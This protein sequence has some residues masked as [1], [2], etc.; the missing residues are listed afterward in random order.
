[1]AVSPAGVPFESLDGEAAHVFVLLISPQ[2]RPGD[3]LRALRACQA[4][5]V[6]LALQ[7]CFNAFVGCSLN[8]QEVRVAIQS[9]RALIQ[10]G[11]VAGNHL[12]VTADQMAFREM[13][14]I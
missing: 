9:I 1:M 6:E 13:N 2:D 7:D 14:S 4:S 3:H 5:F 12:L 8:T 11:D 10:E